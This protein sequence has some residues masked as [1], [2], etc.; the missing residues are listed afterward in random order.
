MKKLGLIDKA[1]ILKRTP[2]FQTLDLDLILTCA[3]KLGIST[4]QKDEIIF[5]I[6]EEAHRMFI[7]AKGSVRLENEAGQKSTVKGIEFFG[8][9]SL[10]SDK[11]RT[12]RA[13]ADDDNTYLLTL[14][15]TN[16]FTMISECPSI[17]VG[18]LQV[19]A[20]K[21]RVFS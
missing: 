11:V 10:F 21:D 8:D 14:S 16:L 6:G 4:F 5:E 18:F 3:D 19:Y 13:V 9:E 15:K 7:V 1:F 20:L 12:Y 17:G 2:L